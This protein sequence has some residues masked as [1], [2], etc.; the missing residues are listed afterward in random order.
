MH[1]AQSRAFFQRNLDEAKRAEKNAR[2]I[3][4]TYQKKELEARKKGNFEAQLRVYED[5][6]AVQS[7]RVKRLTEDLAR[8]D[9]EVAERE[10]Q[11]AQTR[12]DTEAWHV[13]RAWLRGAELVMAQG[14]AEEKAA[15]KRLLGNKK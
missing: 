8:L 9:I 15:F 14:T 1:V 4:E 3:L 10:Q 12:E 11:E 2:A 5:D 13:I 7:E 6:L